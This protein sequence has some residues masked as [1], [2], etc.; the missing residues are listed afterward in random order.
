MSLNV[1][2]S[3]R[4]AEQKLK[5]RRRSKSELG[6]RSAN[7]TALHRFKNGIPWCV[8]SSDGASS[9]ENALTHSTHR[10]TVRAVR[11]WQDDQHGAVKYPSGNHGEGV[12]SKSDAR[13]RASD[14]ITFS[15]NTIW[16]NLPQVKVGAGNDLQ[17]SDML[18]WCTVYYTLFEGL[19]FSFAGVSVPSKWSMSGRWR[20]FP[21]LAATCGKLCVCMYNMRKRKAVTPA[22]RLG[23]VL[24]THARAHAHSL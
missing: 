20:S 8:N 14:G 22:V 3:E 15:Y 6:M 7:A 18:D 21:T 9:R 10:L 1:L 16:Y 4:N 23:S 13:H 5:Y 24:H 17:L 19:V 12:Q 11:P 2:E